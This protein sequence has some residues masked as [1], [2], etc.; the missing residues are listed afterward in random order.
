MEDQIKKRIERKHLILDTNILIDSYKYDKEFVD[1]YNLLKSLNVE[2]VIDSSIKFEFLRSATT[3]E[4]LNK[5]I[6]F[7]SKII[8]AE[9]PIAKE[10]FEAAREISNIYVRNIKNSKQKISFADCLIAGQLKKFNESGERLFFATAN[11]TDFPL[12]IFDRI[13]IY[14]IDLG[15]RI[16]NIGIHVFNNDKFLRQ[17]NK[18]MEIKENKIEELK[19]GDIPF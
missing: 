5:K 1:F 19:I 10:N 2:L 3:K 8:E 17:Q 15:N 16:L 12:L 9:L 11:N 13:H 7:L 6:D 14:T 4:E 18:L